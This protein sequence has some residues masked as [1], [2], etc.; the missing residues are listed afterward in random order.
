M[1]EQRC[2]A[3][4]LIE[5]IDAR[6]RSIAQLRELFRLIA[7]CDRLE[8]WRDSGARDL[9]HWLAMRCGVSEW[10]AR[11]WITCAH[12]LDTLPLT[13]AAFAS[14]DLGIDKVIELTRFATVE[15]EW[16]LLRWAQGVSAAAIRQRADLAVRQSLEEAQEIDRSRRV[17]WWYFDEGRR[18]G[19]EADLPA[20]I[21]ALV[22]RA[23]ERMA[24]RVPRMPDDDA[25]IS[26][27]AR[28]ADALVALCT[29]GGVEGGDA[30]R[31]TVVVHASVESITADDR[32]CEIEGGPWSIPGP[33]GVSC[34]RPASRW[35]LRI[36][37]AGPSA[38][39]RSPGVPR[40]R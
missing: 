27:D 18:F 12:A 36:R 29:G 23:L 32:G 34:A 28:R 5:L 17:S 39:G 6:H 31:S 14:G 38:W 16:R 10:K 4:A 25:A 30:D 7:D 33:L 20:A 37:L 22:A 9:A 3:E 1:A 8:V 15:T 24:A 13:A 35:S 11:R 26:V 40:R 21:G 19:L 2:A